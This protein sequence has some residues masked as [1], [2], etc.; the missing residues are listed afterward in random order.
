MR[1]SI[2]NADF[3]VWSARYRDLELLANLG[4]DRVILHDAV[5]VFSGGPGLNILVH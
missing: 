2:K 4:S 1:S 5:E 3:A